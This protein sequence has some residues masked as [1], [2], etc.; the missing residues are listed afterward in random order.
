MGGVGEMGRSPFWLGNGIDELTAVEHSPRKQRRTV[1]YS[2]PIRNLS[3]RIPTLIGP[4]LS[5]RSRS[6]TSTITSNAPISSCRNCSIRTHCSS[7][8][9]CLMEAENGRQRM[10]TS[11][12]HL[13]RTGYGPLG[14]RST[15]RRGGND[16]GRI[17][18]CVNTTDLG[19]YSTTFGT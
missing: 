14:S 12:I 15:L 3:I 6:C 19:G 8:V 5:L 11:R 1:W 17:S 18:G 2:L 13:G 4:G 16:M 10:G 9:I 7:L